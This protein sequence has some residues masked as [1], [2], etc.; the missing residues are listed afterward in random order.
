[1][2]QDIEMEYLSCLTRVGNVETR[3]AGIMAD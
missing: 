1:M 2:I 3:V